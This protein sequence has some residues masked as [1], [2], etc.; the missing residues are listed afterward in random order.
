MTGNIETLGIPL[1]FLGMI[2]LIM[3][4]IIG[5]RGKWWLKV[6]IIAVTGYLSL[7]LWYSMNGLLGWPTNTSPPEKFQAHWI[8]VQPPKHDDPDSG[9]IFLWATDLQPDKSSK[10]DSNVPSWLEEVLVPFHSK[11]KENE[12]R[13]YSVPYNKELHKQ[14]NQ[15]IEEYLKKG[16]PFMGTMKEP[17]EG[18]KGQGEKGEGES[19]GQG[20]GRP[21][22]QGE[23]SQGEG[24]GQG[25]FSRDDAPP[26]MFYKLPPPKFPDKIGN[27]GS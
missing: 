24:R 9:E 26:P 25:S 2:T 5:G 12:P 6:P 23:Q 13:L 17:A 21:G 10:F 15:I 8:V 1:A 22:P 18:G 4:Y 16:R 19:R 27:S 14:S 3:W 11:H 20:N 7:G